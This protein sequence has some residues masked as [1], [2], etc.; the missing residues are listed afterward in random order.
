[1]DTAQRHLFISTEANTTLYKRQLQETKNRNTNKV[2]FESAFAQSINPIFGKLGAIKLGGSVLKEYA[3]AFGFN[4]PIDSDLTIR[5]PV[6]EI[7]DIP[8]QWAEIASGFNKTTLISPIFG[9]MLTSTILNSGKTPVPCLVE[10]VTDENGNL[11][12]NRK[13]ET[14]HYAVKPGT[15]KTVMKLMNKTVTPGNGQEIL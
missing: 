14:A 5:E 4:Q 2:S 7:T 9:A 1:M 8:Y 3:R 13:N 11:I 15:A 10:S 6:T 12:Y